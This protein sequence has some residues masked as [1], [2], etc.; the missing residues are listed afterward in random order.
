MNNEALAGAFKQRYNRKV[1]VDVLDI[2]PTHNKKTIRYRM[3]DFVITESLSD[4]MTTS[5]SVVFNG[6]ENIFRTYLEAEIF[7]ADKIGEM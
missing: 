5:V 6:K 2:Q 3:D 1:I 4:G 7:V